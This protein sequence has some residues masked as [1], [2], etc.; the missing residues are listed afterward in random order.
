MMLGLM[1]GSLAGCAFAPPD[2]ADGYQRDD[3]GTCQSV[4]Q[5]QDTG[6]G[7]LTGTLTGSIAI[8]VTAVLDLIDPISD[9][10]SG[11]VGLERS[12]DEVSG[13]VSCRFEGQVDGLLGGETFEGTLSGDLSED[14]TAAG[15]LVLELGIFGVLDAARTGS[16]D[17]EGLAGDFSGEL[18]VDVQGV[19]EANVLYSGTF[20][21]TL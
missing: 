12:G 13:T 6:S 1:L 20:E 14:G 18:L 10:C 7:P 19:I 4:P 21:A 17:G 3:A 2:C 8:E 15:P 11:S 9:V 5:G 16:V